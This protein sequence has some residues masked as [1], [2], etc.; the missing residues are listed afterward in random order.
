GGEIYPTSCLR[1]CV[2]SCLS[3]DCPYMHLPPLKLDRPVLEREQR[4]ILPQPNVK[5]GMKFRP[6]LPHDDRAG[7]DRLPA[8]QLHAAVL[9][10]R[11]A[12]VAG[13][14]A[15]FLMSHTS[16]SISFSRPACGPRPTRLNRSSTALYQRTKPPRSSRAG[17]EI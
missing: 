2:P 15:A 12:A 17:G 8:V 14:P 1:A 9:R 16:P 5:P 13:R 3:S 7:G 11:V 10:I 4:V 6:A